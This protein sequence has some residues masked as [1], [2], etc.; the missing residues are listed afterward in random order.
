MHPR[1][2]FIPLPDKILFLD[3]MIHYSFLCV[4]LDFY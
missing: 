4:V 2:Y 1:T 3:N